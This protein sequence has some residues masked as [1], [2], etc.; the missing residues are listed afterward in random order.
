[1]PNRAFQNILF[2]AIIILGIFLRFYRIDS[3]SLWWDEG[4]SFGLALDLKEHGI[5]AFSASHQGDAAAL[6]SDK[7]QALYHILVSL[8]PSSWQPEW[9]MR[10][11]PAITGS[12]SLF[13]LLGILKLQVKKSS[14]ILI[15]LLLAAIS[16][17]LIY[18]SQE[19]RPYSLLFLTDLLFL[20]FVQLYPKQVNMKQCL[21]ITC[22][23]VIIGVT[24]FIGLIVPFSYALA[25]ILLKR[26][27]R[28]LK[29]WLVIGCLST[30]LLLPIFYLIIIHRSAPLPSQGI[31]ISN[32]LYAFYVF[33]VGF[34]LGPTSY[35]LH[36]NRSISAIVS[37]WPLISAVGLAAGFALLRGSVIEWKNK[38]SL[39]LLAVS[40]LSLFMLSIAFF[41]SI[42]PLYP[43]HMMMLFPF[44]LLIIGKG[45]DSI[46]NTILK[47][48]VVIGLIFLMGWSDINFYY[49]EKYFKD[50]V[51]GAAALINN[52][53]QKGDLVLV[54]VMAAFMPYYSGLNQVMQIPKDDQQF[55]AFYDKLKRDHRLWIVINR[56]W[57]FDPYMLK[58]AFLRGES[59]RLDSRNVQI[60][61]PSEK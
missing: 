25:Q 14:Q 34:S 43:R 10:F 6:S 32:Y 11:W 24:Q 3:Q 2:G 20:F 9:K 58:R 57:E 50:D 15:T 27:I 1:M 26:D 22:A 45:L 41:S 30:L 21:V 40:A 29:V 19:G 56:P 55:F 35:E 42:I 53:E 28:T 4:Y 33:I 49:N 60:Y 46:S 13:L 59:S 37:Y 61:F 7:P 16:P 36:L 31:S 18:Y 47:L 54:G 51:R 17:F 52:N 12:L 23:I 38:T 44:F 8:L 48:I 39:Y 5:N